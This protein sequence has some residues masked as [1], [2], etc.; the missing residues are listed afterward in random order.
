MG[1]REQASHSHYQTAVAIER[2]LQAGRVK[3]AATGLQELID[4]LSRSERR[5]LRSH[6]IRLMA[7]IL[8]WQS[9]PPMRSRSWAATIANARDEIADIQEETP[10]LTDDVLRSHLRTAAPALAKRQA[11]AEMD[12]RLRDH[13]LSW[14][15][16]F[17]AEYTEV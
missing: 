15:D 10:S 2:E 13:E 11:E 7:H 9:Q 12:V 8:K 1:W 16:V 5:A 3:E 17:E 6:L 14:Q 4:A